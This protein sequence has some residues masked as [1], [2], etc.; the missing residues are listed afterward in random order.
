MSALLVALIAGIGAGALYAML[1][2]GIVV[3]FR[4]SGVI[5]F[6]H[7][8]VAGYTAYSFD[9]LRESGSLYLP[10]FDPIPEFGFLQT[11][12]INNLPVRIDIFDNV[13][14]TE[15]P[16]LAVTF[17]ICLLMSAFL[18]L[19]MHFL[20][21]RPLRNS[22]TLGKVIG[23]IGVFLYLSSM[24]AVHFGGQNRYDEGFSGFNSTSGAVKNFLGLG[25][26]IPRSN[27][28]LFGAAL[29]MCLA[30][31]ALYRYSRFGIATRAADEN[32]KGA[33][34]LGYSPQF[35]AGA[36][37]VLASVTAGVAGILFLH[38]TQ[39][40][41]IALFVVGGLGAALFGNLTS[42]PGATMGG[43]IIGMIASG[44]VELTTNSW[45]PDIIPGDGVRNFMPLLIIILVLYFRG[46]KLPIRGSISIGRQPRAP[47][48]NNVIIGAIA[49]LGIGLLLS[50]IF[51][52]KWEAVL[53]TTIIAIVFM[54]SLTV[55]IGFL[56][57]ISLVQWTI[58][59]LAAYTMIRLMADGTKIRETDFV[60]N[61]GWGWP[62]VLAFIAAIVVAVV[63]GLLVGLP[64]LRIR[65]VQLA[66][67]TIAAVI[68]VESLLLR[69]PPLMG[70]GSVSVNPTPS[71]NWF[72]Q[73]VGGF[74]PNTAR[75]DYWKFSLF[76]IILAGLIGVGV[77]NL[78]RGQIGRRFL[79]IRANERA[80]AAAGINVA[81]M[82]L[83][84]FGISSGIAAIAGC[85]LAYKLPGLQTDQFEIFGGLALL[86]FAYL[87]GI[88]TVWGA[89][90]GGCLIAG[91]LMPEFLGVHFES[92]DTGL[93]NA[94]GAIGL[95]VN[96]KVTN[97][98]GVALLQTDLA[99][100][101]LAALRRE[102]DQAE[103]ADENANNDTEEVTA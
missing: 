36:N 2:S 69:N 18:G 31:W 32:E 67:V 29:V 16:N 83:L 98:E 65:G 101:T 26:T 56:G 90:V 15:K 66:V 76:I 14:L 89:I 79:A 28:F 97:G 96:A 75:T 87:G 73:Y 77:A 24:C 57:Q 5:N 9:E 63:F 62:T 20:V 80:A 58:S 52:S 25:G 23:S 49:A 64:A 13:T 103:E 102:P 94:V 60:T 1:G 19:L 72:G 55:L 11:L 4:G 17:I 45:W 100:N 30:V 51:V 7:G 12:R 91:G 86:A 35:L 95:V 71:P 33:A 10:W 78:R 42:I 70:D 84:G 59:G 93:I 43:L 38:K 37:W 44:G 54:Y 48:S 39:P 88:T 6:G 47:T 27:F 41:Q 46:D 8:A 85:M 92:V 21:F 50:N 68:A 61:T 82:K 40:A 53:T 74:N 99:K 3:A 34:L 22:P 81:N